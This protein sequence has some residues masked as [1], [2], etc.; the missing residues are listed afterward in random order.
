MKRK[1]LVLQKIRETGFR[2]T[3]QRLA[4][5]EY[6]IGNRE[7]PSV[8]KIYSDLKPK[9]PMLSLSTV[10][11]TVKVLKAIG[12]IQELTISEDRV[13]LEPNLQPHYHFLCLECGRIYDIWPEGEML[14]TRINGHEVRQVQV[15]YYGVCA[16]CQKKSKAAS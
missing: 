1:E 7:H 15:Y 4:I 8:E 10:Y 9:Y 13:Y 11:N 12:E 5:V 2:L 6:L 16:N 14:P 3:P